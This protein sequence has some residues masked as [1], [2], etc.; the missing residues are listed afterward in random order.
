[1]M[2]YHTALLHLLIL[3]RFLLAQ[4]HVDALAQKHN[5]KAIRTAL[6]N[7]PHALDGTYDEAMNRIHGQNKE[8]T[9]LAQRV[10][11]WLS[12]ALRPL[13]VVEMKH[14]ISV[15][16]DQASIDEDD[17]ID[18]E[19]LLSVCAGL[20][21][22]DQESKVIRLIHYT[23]QEYF[24]RNRQKEFPEGQTSIARTCLRY[25]SF[26]VFQ[27][28]YCT[29]DEQ[30]EERL[31]KYPLLQYAAQNWGNHAR[32]DV[33][34][35]LKLQIL[36]FLAQK[37]KVSSMVQVMQIPSYRYKGYSQYPPK[38][39]LSL[40]VA[41]ILNLVDTA[42]TLLAG[43]IDLNI[44]TG[45]E[46]AFCVAASRGYEVMV[47]LLVNKG[48]NIEATDKFGETALWKAASEGHENIV[49]LLLNKGANIEATNGFGETALHGAASGGHESI[50]DLLLNKGANTEA[51]N[52]FGETA[53][54]GAALGGR[55]VVVRLLLNRG[56]NIEAADDSG[57]TPLYWANSTRH[58]SVAQLLLNSGAK[59]EVED[60]SS[61]APT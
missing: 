2:S 21:V 60:I 52:R 20:V 12:F 49:D 17:L 46:T 16:P 31:L 54:H 37:S 30:M 22:I 9:E 28:G 34:R 58:K 13:T 35:I 38:A 55:E 25:I 4:L 51:T 40:W 10:L 47:Q 8:D 7:L 48:A 42:M 36:E 26:E 32:G 41:V 45:E 43:D 53:L 14:A 39:V 5:R 61:R 57:H 29:T 27:S 44:R 50:V 59:T 11:S 18:E 33:E 24:E 6:P 1:V 56:A 23:T 15:Q 3:S 19:I